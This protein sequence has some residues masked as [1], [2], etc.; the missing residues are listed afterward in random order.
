MRS[1][2]FVANQKAFTGQGKVNSI[3][4]SKHNINYSLEG[5]SSTIFATSCF[6]RSA[7]C[8][9]ISKTSSCETTCITGSSTFFPASYEM[10]C[11]KFVRLAGAPL[12]YLGLHFLANA[13]VLNWY[14]NEVSHQTQ[15]QDFEAFFSSSNNLRDCAHTHDISS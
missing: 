10:I 2:H 3:P 6:T 15:N 13:P 7:F 1:F 9:P 5:I 14:H 12:T 11:I 4:T 8:L